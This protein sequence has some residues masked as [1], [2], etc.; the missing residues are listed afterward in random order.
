VKI[1]G[2]ER[3]TNE[4]ASLWDM[5]RA[6]PRFFRNPHGKRET[7]TVYRGFLIN[8]ATDVHACNA[9]IRRTSVFLFLP[10]GYGEE[11][12]HPDMFCVSSCTNVN[13]IPQAKRYIDRLLAHGNYVYGWQEEVNAR[14]ESA[15]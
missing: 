6:C 5:E 10:E 2:E 3:T 11:S 7:H 9:P 15:T 8:R 1:D 14:A 12:P 13:S 4:H